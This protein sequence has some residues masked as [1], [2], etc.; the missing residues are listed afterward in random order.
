VAGDAVIRFDS[1]QQGMAYWGR[2]NGIHD[3]FHR[4]AF[5][6]I[7][8]LRDKP[9]AWR[10]MMLSGVLEGGAKFMERHAHTDRDELA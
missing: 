3:R 4:V 8:L 6:N 2:V 10:R 7:A 9:R 5:R 1:F